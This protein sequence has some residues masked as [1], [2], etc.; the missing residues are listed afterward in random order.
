MVLLCDGL[1]PV[2]II[3]HCRTPHGLFC[4]CCLLM[5][6]SRPQHGVCDSLSLECIIWYCRPQ[7]DLL[8]GGLSPVAKLMKLLTLFVKLKKIKNTA[9]S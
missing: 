9:R 6:L 8:C 5:W 1:L 7:H 2:S 4:D 3:L